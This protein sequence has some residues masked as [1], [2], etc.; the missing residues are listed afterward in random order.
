MNRDD[1]KAL[2]EIDRLDKALLGTTTLRNIRSEETRTLTPEQR[3][4]FFDNRDPSQWECVT[5]QHDHRQR[6]GFTG[7]V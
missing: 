3:A 4:R 1:I 2:V 6:G 7:G 5:A